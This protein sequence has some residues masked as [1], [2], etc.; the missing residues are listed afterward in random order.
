M[1]ENIYIKK[2]VE[3]RKEN[4]KISHI[5]THHVHIRGILDGVIIMKSKKKKK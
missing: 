3:I 1:K 5:S 4:H 2:G